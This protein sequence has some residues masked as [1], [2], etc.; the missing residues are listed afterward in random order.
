MPEEVDLLCLH[1]T[2]RSSL[3]P[4]PM[5]PPV[6]GEEVL[7]PLSPSTGQADTE[8]E[9]WKRMLSSLSFCASSSVSLLLCRAPS[10]CQSQ[11]KLQTPSTAL[12][13]R[14]LGSRQE[15]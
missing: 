12:L 3:V 9:P 8:R 14:F 13:G 10:H 11:E 1:F 7:D 5:C 4:A 6:I 15:P 2:C